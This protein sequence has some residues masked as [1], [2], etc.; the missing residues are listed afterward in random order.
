LNVVPCQIGLPQQADIEGAGKEERHTRE[1]RYSHNKVERLPY[2]EGRKSV[3][4][5]RIR[6]RWMR[7]TMSGIQE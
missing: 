7:G 4:M 6:N 3:L 2:M 1:E 5:M